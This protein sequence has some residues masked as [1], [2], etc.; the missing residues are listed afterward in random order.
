MSTP[1]PPLP[2][3]PQED[4]DPDESRVLLDV[5]ATHRELLASLAAAVADGTDPDDALTGH[6]LLTAF[7]EMID[8]L[9]DV[10]PLPVS[11][12]GPVA[13]AVLVDMTET[14]DRFLTQVDAASL[15]ALLERFTDDGD[16]NDGDEYLADPLTDLDGEAAD[17]DEASQRTL[18][19]YQACVEEMASLFRELAPCIPR[20]IEE[21]VE[22]SEALDRWLV[23][24]PD[25]QVV[26]HQE[27]VASSFA[28]HELLAALD[29]WIDELDDDDFAELHTRFALEPEAVIRE[30][31]QRATFAAQMDAPEG[32]TVESL[33][34]GWEPSAPTSS[35][36]GG[37]DRGDRTDR[38]DRGPERC[39]GPRDEP[40]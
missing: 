20:A 28:P 34:S 25:V 19:A 3:V 21:Y 27:T 13:A 2:P 16:E 39:D 36:R 10:D 22:H 4:S 14:L 15:G 32:L 1:V 24:H 18:D 30:A 8:E 23:E 38:D 31:I 17:L 37:T 40:A 9:P 26:V 29:D 5:M 12:R 7:S 35:H 33:L 11:T 6:E